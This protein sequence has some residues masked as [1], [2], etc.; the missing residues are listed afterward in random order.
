[1]SKCVEMLRRTCKVTTMSDATLQS[2]LAE[3]PRMLGVLFTALLT[4]SQAGNAA[5]GVGTLA[6]YGP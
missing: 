4:L 2:Y 5:A 1:M 3:N 6:V